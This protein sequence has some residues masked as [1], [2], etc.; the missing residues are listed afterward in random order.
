M[1]VTSLSAPSAVCA[2]EI[3]SFALRIAWLM[4]RTCDVI[5]LEIARPAASSLAEL[6]RLPVD[7]RSMAVWR[8]ALAIRLPFCAR[9]ADVLELITVIVGSFPALRGC[10]GGSR[11]CHG[12]Q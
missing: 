9:S 3:P 10:R 11:T 12:M 7:R 5:E 1:L 8:A 6:M 2:S 4:P